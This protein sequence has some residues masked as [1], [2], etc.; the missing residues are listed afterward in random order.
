MYVSRCFES[1]RKDAVPLVPSEVTYEIRPTE[2]MAPYFEER[3]G[4]KLTISK[5]APK[6]VLTIKSIVKTLS[7]GQGQSTNL[8]QH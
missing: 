8:M 7:L 2:L 3:L 1:P 5:L 6:I 4:H